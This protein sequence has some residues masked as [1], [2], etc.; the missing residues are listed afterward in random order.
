MKITSHS[1]WQCRHTYINRNLLSVQCTHNYRAVCMSVAPS[2]SN[3]W[4]QF[5]IAS[6]CTLGFSHSP[7]YSPMKSLLPNWLSLLSVSDML[8]FYSWPPSLHGLISSLS[9]FTNLVF[10]S[11]FISLSPP[12]LSFFS[13]ILHSLQIPHRQ[14][15]F[16][17]C[18]LNHSVF[19]HLHPIHNVPILSCSIFFILSLDFFFFLQ[20]SPFL[21]TLQWFPW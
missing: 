19:R 18:S 9:I 20:L 17:T 3:R 2:Y 5:H 12:F 13:S 21:A 16:L 4:F 7:P 10:L 14:P 8:L 6:P 1:S 11:P 15:L